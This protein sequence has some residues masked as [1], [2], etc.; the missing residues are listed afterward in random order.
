MPRPRRGDLTSLRLSGAERSTAE[1]LAAHVGRV[2]RMGRGRLAEG[3]RAALALA[4]ALAEREGWQS[5]AALIRED[6]R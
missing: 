3:V 5:V 2:D 1:T 4:E 6:P